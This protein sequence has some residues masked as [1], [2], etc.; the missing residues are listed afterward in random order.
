MSDLHLQ[1][2]V[3][4]SQVT[5]Q[6]GKAERPQ[7]FAYNSTITRQAQATD[8]F[9]SPPPHTTSRRALQPRLRLPLWSNITWLA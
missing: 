5:A 1:H 3:A 9:P 8:N 2:T 6:T 4:Q 7:I